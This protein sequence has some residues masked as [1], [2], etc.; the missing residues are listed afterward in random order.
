MIAF[1]ILQAAFSTLF[2]V[3]ILGVVPSYMIRTFVLTVVFVVAIGLLHTLLFLPVLLSTVVPDSEYIEPYRPK[4]PTISV[5]EE[6][7]LVSTFCVFFLPEM[8]QHN[9]S[10]SRRPNSEW[11]V[12]FSF[13]EIVSRNRKNF[14]TL[15]HL[16]SESFDGNKVYSLFLFWSLEHLIKVF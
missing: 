16:N 7:E 3:A 15:R 5:E 11:I 10:I 8:N 4:R 6:N 2:G 9:F 1:P 14:P 12:I 13:K